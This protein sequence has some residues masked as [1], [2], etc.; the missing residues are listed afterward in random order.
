ML[1]PSDEALLDMV[2]SRGAT[3]SLKVLLNDEAFA[4]KLVL[5]SMRFQGDKQSLR[6]DWEHKS[7]AMLSKP[8]SAHLGVFMMHVVPKVLS[9]RHED[10]TEAARLSNR[11][12][13]KRE[14]QDV[15]Q[16]K[17]ATGDSNKEECT[18]QMFPFIDRKTLEMV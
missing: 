2:T 8:I 5:G 17:S 10:V 4:R 7:F 14:K 18:R 16:I 11:K 6:P 15:V 1:A 3:T 13:K 12:P 9:L